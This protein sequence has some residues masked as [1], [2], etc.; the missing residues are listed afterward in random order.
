M[1]LRKVRLEPVKPTRKQTIDREGVSTVSSIPDTR[2]T[3]NR[4]A[5]ALA[6]V[7][8][9]AVASALGGCTQWRTEVVLTADFYRYDTVGIVAEM[10][11]FEENLF[12]PL[13]MDA[14]P[15]QLIVERRDLET[16]LEELN[17]QSERIDADVRERI[18]E[19]SG[20]EALLYPYSERLIRSGRHVG[21]AFALKA[22]DMETGEITAA[23]SV[24]GYGPRGDPASP[25]DA[26]RRGMRDLKREA[27]KQRQ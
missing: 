14:F 6:L 27:T 2:R 20:I 4:S 23:L 26:I 11:R 19:I 22:I 12:I 25:E 24:V 3:G 18:R 1:A 17:V 16:L 8:V 9:A 21:S 13:Y 7:L 15:H 10:D 5:R